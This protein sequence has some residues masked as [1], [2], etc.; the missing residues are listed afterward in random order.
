VGH[1]VEFH[2]R[3][4]STVRGVLVRA[5]RYEVLLRTADGER[6]VL[7]HAVDWTALT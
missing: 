3:D 7:K 1:E 5:W 4:G 6:L 2:L